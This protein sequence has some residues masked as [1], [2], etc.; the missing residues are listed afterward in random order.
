MVLANTYTVGSLVRARG[1]EWVVLPQEEEDVL[2]LR[3]LGGTEADAAG[4]YLPIEG[5]DISSATF[6]PPDPA[7]A[8]DS[9]AAGLL[10]DAVRLNFRA[11]AGPFRS[12][13]RVAVEPR[14]YQ[15]VP[16][17]MALRL[18]PVRLLIA[19]DVGIGKTVEAALI[20]RELLD[21]G[22][23]SRLAVLCPPHLCDQWQAELAT[24]FHLDAEV[25]RPGTVA[26]LERGLPINRS[27]FDVYPFVVVSV[28]YIKADRRRADFVRACPEF[29]IVDEAHA[30]AS[31]ATTSGGQHQRHQLVAELARDPNRHLVLTTATPHSGVEASFRSLLGLLDPA[32]AAL[33]ED[34]TRV[35]DEAMRRRLAAHFVQ[36][37]RADIRAYLDERTTFPE[38][39]STE[40]TYQLGADYRRL[41]EQVQAYATDLVRSA[42]GMSRFRQRVCWWAALAL[43]RCVT[44]S[45]AAAAATL[46]TRAGGVAEDGIDAALDLAGLEALGERSV[47]DLDA[48]DAADG[49]DVVPGADAVEGDGPEAG[50]RARLRRLA[51]EAAALG[52]DKDQKLLGAVDL[53]SGLIAD[54]FRPVVYCR[55]VATAEYVAAELARRLKD[56][57]V[58]A[59]TGR[60]PAEERARRVEALQGHERRVLVATDC[61]SEGINLQAGFDAVLHYDLSWNPTRHEQREGRVDR[62]GQP[63]PEVRT[64]LYYGEDNRVD[65]AIMKVLLRKAETIRKELGVSVPVP[66]D[67]TKV[68][69]AVFEALFL[70]KADPRQMTL[71]FGDAERRLEQAALDWDRASAREKRSWT[72]FAQG[73]IRPEEVARELREAA[74][75]LG[76]HNDT[77]RFVRDACARLGAPLNRAPGRPGEAERWLLSPQLLP[78]PVRDRAGLDGA[79][80]LPMGF[81]LPVPDRT[82]HVARTHPLVEALG[83]HLVDTALD[84]LLDGVAARSGAI[85]TRS[86]TGRTT[87][88]LLRVR[89]HLEV[90]RRGET[91]PLLAEEV[92]VA[93]FRGRG[94]DPTWLSQAEAEALLASEPSGNV[95]P[96]Q[97]EQWLRDALTDLDAH[98]PGIEQ[99]ARER[100]DEVLVAH[101]RVR[102]AAGMTGIRYAVRPT[103]PADV[104]GLY[105]LMPTA[106]AIA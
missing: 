99:L 104:L 64:I 25:V 100:A 49:D 20:A 61:L 48:S 6:P 31:G 21:R 54:G 60:L 11:G 13:G 92:L 29:V 74:D 51:R 81:E 3:P 85:R 68:L 71:Q 24:K 86:V 37:R 27:I 72:V 69:E 41:F 42:S 58:D 38:R 94:A 83:A 101:R 96:G 46:T 95:P 30:C 43:L 52:G 93:G 78:A 5:D 7:R 22:E 98:Q 18:A 80:S 12:L 59:V 90:T 89:M 19:D 1:R 62:Y 67:S 77:A 44:S 102:D 91:T 4:L 34:E 73:A 106:A 84:P 50:E 33:P 103:L 36:R 16:L 35:L 32:F 66:T 55:Y 2:L 28:D 10:R 23:I 88:L 47:L 40:A 53:L 75:A 79:T 97:K 8:G 17:L 39:L 76:D 57:T 9:T 14:P 15:L 45:P 63:K 87:L 82:L 56:V 65:G 105:V 26:R 70:T